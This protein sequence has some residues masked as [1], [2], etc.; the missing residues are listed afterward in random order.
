MLVQVLPR[1]PVGVRAPGQVSWLSDRPTP[2]AFP[3]P[4]LSGQWLHAGFVPDY[5]DGVAADS[6]RLPWGPHLA[7]RPDANDAVT[8]ADGQSGRKRGEIRSTAA[9]GPAGPRPPGPDFSFRFFRLARV[10]SRAHAARVRIAIVLVV[11]LVLVQTVER[12][13]ARAHEAPDGRALAGPRAAAGDGAT[14][15]AEGCAGNRAD[16]AVLDRV[17][18][19]VPLPRLRGRV[20]VARVD[21][22]LSRHSRRRRRR[23]A[24]HA[25][26]RTARGR[27]GPLPVAVLARPVGH[28]EARRQRGHDHEGHA[29]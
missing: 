18:R 1:G 13:T 10:A 22:R 21:R 12:A 28:D 8:V 6:H 4:R 29:D 14:R 3:A 2:R 25:G 20:L 16:G 7:G 9:D 27:I 23:G 5:S 11:L 19:L 26:R 24:R 17:D 15:R